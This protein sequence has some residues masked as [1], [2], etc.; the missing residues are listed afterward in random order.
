MSREGHPRRLAPNISVGQGDSLPG[1]S[2]PAFELSRVK[3]MK[4]DTY[5]LGTDAFAGDCLSHIIAAS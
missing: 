2:R 4:L 1:G 3:Y 5:G